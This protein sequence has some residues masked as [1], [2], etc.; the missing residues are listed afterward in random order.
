MHSLNLAN[1]IVMATT[2]Y[3]HVGQVGEES[4]SQIGML[5]SLG[6]GTRSS[7]ISYVYYVCINIY[8]YIYNLH[9]FSSRWKSVLFRPPA[10]CKGVGHTLP[11]I[12]RSLVEMENSSPGIKRTLATSMSRAKTRSD[13]RV[14]LRIKSSSSQSLNLTWNPTMAIHTNHWCRVPNYQKKRQIEVSKLAKWA[15]FTYM[16][17]HL[18]F[19]GLHVHSPLDPLCLSSLPF[20]YRKKCLGQLCNQSLAVNFKLCPR[21]TYLYPWKYVQVP[22]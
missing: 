22:Q 17:I 19:S 14:T 18:K 20:E 9:I 11:K 13:Q 5:S 12:I 3:C 7:S 10:R 4:N 15:G 6:G 2:S 16:S 1:D 21:Q 8:I